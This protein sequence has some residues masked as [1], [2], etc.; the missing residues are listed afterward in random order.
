MSILSRAVATVARCI[1]QDSENISANES[2]NRAI[3]DITLTVHDARRRRFA[4]FEAIPPDCSWPRPAGRIGIISVDPPPTLGAQ[5]DARPV[6]SRRD[7]GLKRP[8][9]G[10]GQASGP[11]A[12][13][14]RPRER[15]LSPPNGDRRGGGP[16]NSTPTRARTLVRERKPGRPGIGRRDPDVCGSRIVHWVGD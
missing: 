8:R 3:E 11:I 9:G 4:E 2:F 6:S 14:C 7:R 10:R 1:Q 12:R 15:R 16:A 13:P 5:T